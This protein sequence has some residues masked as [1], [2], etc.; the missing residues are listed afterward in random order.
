MKHH[1]AKRNENG[2]VMKRKK[3]VFITIIMSQFSVITLHPKMSENEVSSDGLAQLNPAT[4][5]L[6]KKELSRC[7]N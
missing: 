4:H 5:Y 3:N 6:Q 7:E 2:K 1:A